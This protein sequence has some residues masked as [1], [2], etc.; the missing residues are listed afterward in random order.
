MAAGSL[1]ED[2]PEVHPS[3]A[4]EVVEPSATPLG[5]QPMPLWMEAKHLVHEARADAPCT[6]ASRNLKRPIAAPELALLSDRTPE[7]VG[8]FPAEP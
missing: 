8:V 2:E 5:E 7:V 3:S 4:P 6:R 1:R